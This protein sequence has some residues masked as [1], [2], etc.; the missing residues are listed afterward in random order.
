[1]RILLIDDSTTM[2][3]IQ[4]TQINGLGIT[5]VIEAGDGEEGLKKTG[6]EYAH[7]SHYAG[8]EHAGDGWAYLSKKS[9][10]HGC[11]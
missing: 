11:L 4:K 5:D 3:R 6:A 2:R 10:Y 9:T 8:L 1:M 7:R